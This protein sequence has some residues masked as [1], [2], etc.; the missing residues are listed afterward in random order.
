[1]PINY[2]NLA[3]KLVN[4]TEYE[5]FWYAIIGKKGLKYGEQCDT[6][7]YCQRNFFCCC[8][9]ELSATTLRSPSLSHSFLEDFKPTCVQPGS[10]L[11]RDV[12]ELIELKWHQDSS[13]QH[14]INGYTHRQMLFTSKSSNVN[15][16]QSKPAHNWY[17]QFKRN[18]NRQQ[19]ANWCN[20]QL[21]SAYV[22]WMVTT[23][24]T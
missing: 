7:I 9:L 18:E 1:M 10:D 21:D 24:G 11:L 19:V 23:T 8:H 12:L 4:I 6:S 5:K 13:Q 15:D 3:E 20:T 22:Q 14:C 16:C 17:K 2:I